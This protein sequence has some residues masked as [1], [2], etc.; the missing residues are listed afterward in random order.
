MKININI[1]ID[2]NKLELRFLRKY[3]TT[4]QRINQILLQIKKENRWIA[5]PTKSLLESGILQITDNIG[6]VELTLLGRL[7]MDKID[8]NNLIDD[9]LST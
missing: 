5:E 1:E 6:T 2:L 9:L 4:N 7:L 8:R 3:F